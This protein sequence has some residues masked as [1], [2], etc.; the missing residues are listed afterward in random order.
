MTGQKRLRDEQAADVA[1]AVRMRKLDGF[2]DARNRLGDNLDG[3]VRDCPATPDLPLSGSWWCS[4]REAELDSWE[5]VLQ[6][7]SDECGCDLLLAFD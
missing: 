3:V 6:H 5:D 7:R 1:R 2:W 4:D